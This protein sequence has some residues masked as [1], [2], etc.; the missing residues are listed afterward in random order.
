DN[1]KQY[2][3]YLTNNKE[4]QKQIEEINK[5]SSNNQHESSELTYQTHKLAN[6]TSEL[7]NVQNVPEPVN[8]MNAGEGITMV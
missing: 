8:T 2:R 6:Y 1:L 3:Q 4:L 5:S 7:L